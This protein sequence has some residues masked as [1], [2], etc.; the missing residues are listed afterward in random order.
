LD[1]E[2]EPYGLTL[3]ETSEDE[4]KM[5]AKEVAEEYKEYE[6]LENDCYTVYSVK[7]TQNTWEVSSST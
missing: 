4:V 6:D 2:I 7:G 3:N 1:K 5:W